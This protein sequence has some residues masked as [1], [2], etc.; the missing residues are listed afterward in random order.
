[1]RGLHGQIVDNL[2]RRIVSGQ[3]APGESLSQES[4]LDEFGIS[5]TVLRE[6][7]RVLADKGL[8]SSRQR[9]GTQI[10]AR[11]SWRLLDSDMLRWLGSQP[12]DSFLD[13]LAEVRAIVEPA[14]AR[15][16]AERR[17]DEDVAKLR[18]ALDAM[19]TAAANS[20]AEAAIEADLAFHRALL[21]S[22]HNELMSRM[23]IVIEAG[24]RARNER[25]HAG[26]HVPEFVSV[27]AAIVDAVEAGDGEAA[28]AATIALLE[29]ATRDTSIAA[30]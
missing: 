18:S 15:F 23:E 20:D 2:G 7:M 29:Q 22:M 14:S 9:L 17:S 16:A 1:M 11:T 13:Q 19:A 27:H 3:Y 5:R 25:V 30:D 10:A 12:D 4:L 24:L 26:Q 21:D 28:A 6:A 8:V